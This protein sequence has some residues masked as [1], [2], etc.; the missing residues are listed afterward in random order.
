M[1]DLYNELSRK[2]E[3]LR[4][5]SSAE[6]ILQWDMETMMRPK[7]VEVR[8][9]QLTLIERVGHKIMTDPELGR[10]INKILSYPSFGMLNEVQ[11]RNVRLMKK[12]YDEST[13]LPEEL[14]C[15]T[16][17]QKAITINIWKKAKVSENYSIFKPELEKLF[18]LRMKAAEILMNVK[19]TKNPYDALID[20]YEPKVTSEGI[21]NDMKTSL[22]WIID[23]CGNTSLDTPLLG[24]KVPIQDQRKIADLLANFLGYDTSSKDARGCIDETEHPF[25][26]GYYD[27]VRITTHYY[28]DRFLSSIYSILH[29]VGHRHLR[30]GAA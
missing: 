16:A 21:F 18:E 15:E 19:E 11:S 29:E 4:T 1:L 6:S 14:V 3:E 23:K 26:T 28:E 13:R 9:R 12:A 27:D 7:G 5:L 22:S 24:L 17:R 8:S 20:I 30:A 25:T 10:L 2:A